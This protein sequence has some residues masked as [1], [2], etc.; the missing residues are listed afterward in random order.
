MRRPSRR[1]LVGSP[2]RACEGFTDDAEKFDELRGKITAEGKKDAIEWCTEM[3]NREEDVE[4]GSCS[5][6]VH[7]AAVGL[8]DKATESRKASAALMEAILAKVDAD[9]VLSLSKPLGKDMRAAVDAHLNRPQSVRSSLKSI[10]STVVAT[11]RMKGTA[12]LETPLVKQPRWAALRRLLNR[13]PSHRPDRY[14]CKIQTRQ[15]GFVNTR[16]K[17]ESLKLCERKIS[18]SSR[19][20]STPPAIPTSDLMCT[21]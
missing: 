14:F 4:D 10:G 7:F 12:A 11:N 3:F 17:R 18:P 5:S 16:A 20:S 13:H 6:A 2:L 21:K 15:R 8:S 1:A 19:A 9:K